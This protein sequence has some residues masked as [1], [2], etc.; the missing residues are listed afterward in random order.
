MD[1]IAVNYTN[2]GSSTSQAPCY[3]MKYDGKWYPDSCDNGK[4]YMCETTGEYVFDFSNVDS[5]NVLDKI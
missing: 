3:M 1:G 5:S 4:S 2:Y